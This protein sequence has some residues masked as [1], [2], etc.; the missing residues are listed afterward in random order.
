MARD[1]F[2]RRRRLVAA[3]HDPPL[4]HVSDVAQVLGVSTEAAR[5]HICKHGLREYSLPQPFARGRYFEIAA[6]QA[7]ADELKNQ[8]HNHIRT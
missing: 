8:A 1:D 3:K 7:L 4:V 5:H 6:V 2:K